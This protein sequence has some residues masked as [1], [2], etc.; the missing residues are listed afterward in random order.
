MMRKILYVAALM[1]AVVSASAQSSSYEQRY[2]LLVSKFGPA[3]IGVETVLDNWAKTDSTNIKLLTARFKYYFTKAQRSEVVKKSTK[4]YLGMDPL[5]SLKDT[6]G[7]DVYY[8]QETFYDDELY[9]LALKAADKA[10]YF[11]PDDLD[12]RFMKA[13]A[14]ISYEK[15]S[16]DMALASLVALVDEEAQRKK[17]W[18]YE[19]EEAPEDFFQEAMQEYCYSFYAI[20]ST[21]AMKAFLKLSQKMNAL[22]PESPVFMNN[23]G[24]YYMVAEKDYKTALKYY[25]KVQK[26]FPDDYTA[27]KNGSLAAKMSGNQ[28]LEKKFLQALARLKSTE[29]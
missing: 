29:E 12:F 10:I 1:L 3:G 7:N 20:G 18:K 19:G 28:K 4:K 26:K 15:E 27:I 9:G 5:I 16:P 11:H 2:D 22:Y 17:V 13:N 23:I 8:Y 24:S 14:Y 25:A 6:T 21:G